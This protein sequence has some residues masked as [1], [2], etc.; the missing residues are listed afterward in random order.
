MAKNSSLNTKPATLYKLM[1][2]YMLKLAGQPLT[3]AQ[4]YDFMGDGQ[5][6]DY[7]KVNSILNELM[8]TGLIASQT[9]RNTSHLMI[10][11][12]GKDTIDMFPNEIPDDIKKEIR[13][14][15]T[16]KDYEL[17]NEESIQTGIDRLDDGSYL[18]ELTI[19]EAGSDLLNIRVALPS[20]TD[21]ESVCI[22]FEKKHGELYQYIMQELFKGEK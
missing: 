18:A 22:N 21:A 20:K 12:S 1:I 15:L 13:Q 10:T 5:Y 2:L 17:R 3:T 9:R 16:E 19:K 7:F 8:D 11:D 4:L 14:Y 6:A